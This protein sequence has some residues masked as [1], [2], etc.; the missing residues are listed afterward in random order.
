MPSNLRFIDLFAGLGGFHLAL[1]E[2]GHNCVFACE[3]DEGLRELY[4]K[5]FGFKPSGDIRQLDLKSIPP[6]DVLCAGFPCQPFSKA[7]KQ[8]GLD[9]PD[10]G[11][12]FDYVARILRRHRPAFFL[13]ENVPNLLRHNERDTYASMQRKL[14]RIGYDVREA[15]LSPHHFGIPQ[16]RERA[17]IVGSLSK[18]STFAWPTKHIAQQTSIEPLLDKSPQGARP[19]SSE[20]QAALEVWQEFIQTF[21][22]AEELPSFPI[23]SMEFGADYP[24]ESETPFAIGNRRLANYRGAHG[25]PLKRISP[26]ERMRQLPGY[27]QTEE[28]EFPEWKKDFIRQNRELYQTNKKWIR[29]WLPKIRAFHPSWQKLE[30]N[31]K[32]EMRNIWRYIIQFRASGVRVKRPSSSPSLIA[33]TTTQVPIVGWEKRYMTP[34]ECA[35]LQNL[36][37]LKHLPS[38]P[39]RAYQALGNA[40]NAEVVRLIAQRLFEA[41]RPLRQSLAPTHFLEAA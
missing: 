14:K 33:M 19:L 5:N 2:L 4:E 39:S 32:G 8:E 21:P 1:S 10:H 37:Q 3:L 31:C 20:A 23:W 17:Y 9:C 35:R 30:W 11:D 22:V 7:G 6:H 28:E 38:V 36:G 34:W 15:L 40:V 24:F 16:V 27:A 13:L 29:G 12:L 41:G 26:K 18:L 25:L